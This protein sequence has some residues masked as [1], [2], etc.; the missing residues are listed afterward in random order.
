MRYDAANCDTLLDGLSLNRHFKLA[1]EFE[2]LIAVRNF[3]DRELAQTIQ[4]ECFHTETRQHAPVN[5]RFPKIVEMHRLHGARK[6]S[7]HAPGEGVP[8][9]GWIMDVFERICATTEELI[10]FTK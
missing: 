4:T 7:R 2:G 5:H 8:C 6:K 9:P 10:F 1:H 3:F